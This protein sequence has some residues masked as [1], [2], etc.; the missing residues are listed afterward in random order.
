MNEA[1]GWRLARV[2][3]VTEEPSQVPKSCVVFTPRPLADAMVRALGDQQFATWLEPCVGE[4]VFLEALAAAKVPPNRIRGLDIETTSSPQDQ[5]AQTLRGEEFFRWSESTTERFSRIVANPPYI[6][7]NRMPAAV[8][9]AALGIR[10]PGTTR[11]VTRG[12][13]SWFAFLCANIAL[14]RV[15]GSL[16]FLLPAAWEFADYAAPLRASIRQLFETVEVHRCRQPLFK[17]VLEG[18][19]V[20]LARHYHGELSLDKAPLMRRVSYRTPGTLIT[21]IAASRPAVLSSEVRVISISTCTRLDLLQ[22]AETAQPDANT[23]RT[24]TIPKAAKRLGDVIEIRLGGVTGDANYFVLSDEE[25]IQ[26]GLPCSVCRPIISRARHLTA[27]AIATDY[28]SQLRDDGER[29]WLFDPRPSQTGIEAVKRY[30]NLRPQ[31]GGCDRAAL[32]VRSRDP[33]Y[34]TPIQ[35]N[36]DGFMSGM[37]GWGPWVVFRKMPRLAATNTLYVVRF[38]AGQTTDERAAWAMWLLTSESAHYLHRVGRRY[39]DGLVKFEP[40]DIAQLPIAT[41]L[42]IAGAYSAYE[43]AVRLLLKGQKAACRREADKWF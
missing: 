29:V 4:G 17:A 9:E 1:A 41:P 23:R 12:A 13:N 34:R 20:L 31:H 7:L 6:A 5:L 21:A 24:T 39:A 33:W 32:K 25:R 36:I 42:R 26:L 43:R 3:P 22:R 11:Q 38:H 35:R 19:V 2:E 18:C 16:A 8:Q 15:R 30:L 14:L 37:S 28:W 40:G 27:G 10:V